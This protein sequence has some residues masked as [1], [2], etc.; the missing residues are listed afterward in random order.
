[1]AIKYYK[2]EVDKKP[3][4]NA[5]VS[6]STKQKFNAVVVYL[7]CGNI[8]ATADSTGI[9]RRTLM[10]W[11]A[12]DWWKKFE[13]EI[14]ISKNISK[15][16]KLET[17]VGKAITHLEDRIDNGDV[18]LNPRTRQVERIPVSAKTLN[19]IV[20]DTLDKQVTLEK[21]NRDLETPTVTNQDIVQRLDA[22]KDY[23]KKLAFEKKK[24]DAKDFLEV[25]SYEIQTIPATIAGQ[26][27]RE[28]EFFA[29]SLEE[30]ASEGVNDA[31]L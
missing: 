14:K 12:T 1:M 3:T 22:M 20:K 25:P 31:E 17:V 9:S 29:G 5:S 28:D 7:G 11:K 26:R 15:T 18:V 19:S 10:Y 30:E 13:E 8:Q 24:R 23:M 6:Y 21:L 2:R 16:Q 4:D 27:E